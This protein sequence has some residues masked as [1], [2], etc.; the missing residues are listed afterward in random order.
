MAPAM[1]TETVVTDETTMT[2]GTA[3]T[4][5]ADAT[6]GA[7]VT[8]H[9]TTVTV[10]YPGGAVADTVIMVDATP[11]RWAKRAQTTPAPATRRSTRIREREQKRVRFADEWAE[12]L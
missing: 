3:K 9:G 2:G 6:A 8:I 5:T 11:K 4:A 7:V 10:A 12:N 1:T